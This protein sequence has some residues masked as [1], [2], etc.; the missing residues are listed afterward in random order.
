LQLKN[1]VMM[2]MIKSMIKNVV[3]L[4]TMIKSTIKNVVV[5]MM[6]IK[7]STTNKFNAAVMAIMMSKSRSMSDKGM[8]IVM[9]QELY[10]TS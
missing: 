3:A 4:M 5:M 9:I 8:N 1:A 2:M 6:M 7:K 10:K